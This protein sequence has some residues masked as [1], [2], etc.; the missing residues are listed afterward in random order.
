MCDFLGG[1]IL[2]PWLLAGPGERLAYL[3]ELIR[4]EQMW[5]RRLALVATVWLNRKS[6]EHADLTLSLVDRVLDERDPMIAKA[7]SWALRELIGRHRDR[8][9]AYLEER[10]DRLASLPRR[11]TRNKL[12]TGRKSGRA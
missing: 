2:G 3:D 6:D 11:E 8:V 5:S 7:V 10:G 4:D 1:G 12:E 9:A